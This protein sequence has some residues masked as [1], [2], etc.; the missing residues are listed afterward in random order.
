[1]K[2]EDEDD[3]ISSNVFE[4]SMIYQCDGAASI[5]TTEESADSEEV[6]DETDSEEV[7]DET[8]P[9]I[10]DNEHETSDLESIVQYQSD[11]SDQNEALGSDDDNEN[12]QSQ[13][14]E[15]NYDDD[16]DGEVHNIQVQINYNRQP[17]D[18]EHRTRELR[19]LQTI[20]Q[21][22]EAS[23]SLPTIAVTNF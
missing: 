4:E 6:E 17:R 7:E 5:C 22:S 9:T 12:E 19:T 11:E 10:N 8:E 20:S 1:M 16:N 15:D 13:T 3:D 18:R 14:G 23:L 2:E 21:K